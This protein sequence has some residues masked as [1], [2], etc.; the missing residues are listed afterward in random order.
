MLISVA[1]SNTGGANSSRSCL[2]VARKLGMPTH[3]APIVCPPESTVGAATDRAC[4][5]NS[6]SFSAK[7]SS[8]IRRRELLHQRLPIVDGATRVRHQLVS[9][10]QPFN[11][12]LRQEGKD[13]LA[14][15]SGVHWPTGSR[16]TPQLDTMRGRD[17]IQKNDFSLV[18]HPRNAV[19]DVS[20]A[21]RSSPVERR[22][23][24]SPLHRLGEQATRSA[25]P[26]VA[27]A[28]GILHR[29]ASFQYLE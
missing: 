1:T 29:K 17:A 9:G 20:F 3:T 4:S 2:S 15:G 16:W 11:A 28:G 21:R 7:P 6:Q 13:G 8:R 14:E 22:P 10:K 12:A 24:E 23:P 18:E 26:G 25:V 5:S 19:S 27:L